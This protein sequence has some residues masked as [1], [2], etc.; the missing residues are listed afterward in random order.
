MLAGHKVLME[1]DDNSS[2]IVGNPQGILGQPIHL[3]NINIVTLIN[4]QITCIK[5]NSKPMTILSKCLYGSQEARVFLL[6]KN[7]YATV[8]FVSM[9]SMPHSLAG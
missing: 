6:C 9:E 2:L 8:I 7:I 3:L 5:K 1:V 4:Y